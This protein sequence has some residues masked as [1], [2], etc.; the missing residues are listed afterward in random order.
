MEKYCSET[1]T[2]FDTKKDICYFIESNSQTLDL[3]SDF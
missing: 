2:G 1:F 3:W